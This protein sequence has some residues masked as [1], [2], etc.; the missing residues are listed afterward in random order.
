MDRFYRQPKK[1]YKITKT[2]FGVKYNKQNKD[3]MSVEFTLDETKRI[4]F[5]VNEYAKL[6]TQCNEL[7]MVI[8]ESEAGLSLVLGAIGKLKHDEWNLF[9]NLARKKNLEIREVQ[10]AAADLLLNQNNV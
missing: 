8:K 10:K 4:K 3:N 9:S 7:E 5:L 2:L 1:I 6:K